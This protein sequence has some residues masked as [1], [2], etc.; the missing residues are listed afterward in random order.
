VQVVIRS[1]AGVF[2]NGVIARADHQLQANDSV[3]T[4]IETPNQ[5]RDWTDPKRTDQ[6]FKV[7]AP[8][9]MLEIEKG[10]DPVDAGG[11]TTYTVRVLNPTKE[12][13]K[14][15][16]LTVSVPAELTILDGRGPTQAKKGDRKIVFEPLPLLGPGQESTYAVKV[17]AGKPGVV[18]LK[19]EV[20]SDSVPQ[21][22]VISQEEKVTVLQPK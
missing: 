17:Q 11:E 3:E 20:T 12:T 7:E 18:Q 14:N 8:T 19:A 6:W 4:T 2:K 16:R 21:G 5:R 10:A 15:L 1:G 13:E 9:V 22:R